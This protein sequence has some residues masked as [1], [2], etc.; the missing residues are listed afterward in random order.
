MWEHFSDQTGDW[1]LDEW[2]SRSTQGAYY[3]WAVGNA[4]VPEEDTYHTG[5]Q[6]IDRTTI[7]AL[8]ALATASTTFQTTIDNA[9]AHLNPLGLSPDAIAFDI[10]PSKMLAGQSHFEQIYGRALQSSTCERSLHPGGLNDTLPARPAES[11][12]QLHQ[13]HRGAGDFLCQ[14]VD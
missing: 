6:K 3:H 14:R 1:G 11:D 8:A 10:S 4:L 12:R 5:V 9:N 7:P 13:R 2:V